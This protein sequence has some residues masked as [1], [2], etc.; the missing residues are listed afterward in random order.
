VPP[1]LQSRLPS[2]QTTLGLTAKFA[3]FLVYGAARCGKTT[4]ALTA[5]EPLVLATELGDT[6]GLQSLRDSDVPF[7]PI[8]SSEEFTLVVAEL[9]KNREAAE[10]EGHRFKTIF[11]DSYT[12]LGGLWM[13]AGT[14][15]I[16]GSPDTM[17]W[18][19]AKGVGKD[20]RNVYAY[21]AEKG[22][23][24]T[25]H[26]FDV[27]AHIVMLCREGL[28]TEGEGNAQINYA[29]PEIPGQKLSRELPGWP[30]FTFRMRFVNKN[31]VFVTTTEDRAVAG[32]RLPGS[33]HLP[34]FIKPNIALCIR[35]MLG[36]LDALRAL[37][38][39]AETTAPPTVRRT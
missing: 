8:E 21:F 28:V 26:L 25:K 29:V 11:T 35:V 31:R 15:A 1:K 22:R 2:L 34:A 9:N 18:D 32:P 36:D 37:S 24:E 7:I 38:L 27:R 10:Y 20:P 23:A 33:L 3:T 6:K 17:L 4:L 14:E 30:D 13:E 39:T 19:K 16:T 12:A 5:E